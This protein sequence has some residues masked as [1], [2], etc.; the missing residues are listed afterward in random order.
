MTQTRDTP[1]LDVSEAENYA[2]LRIFK[3]SS[4]RTSAAILASF[5]KLK[6]TL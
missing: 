1:G 5:S 4:L 2:P 3:A 6:L